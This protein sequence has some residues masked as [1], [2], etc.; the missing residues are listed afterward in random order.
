VLRV[1]AV[2]GLLFEEIIDPAGHKLQMLHSALRH[3]S[4]SAKSSDGIGTEVVKSV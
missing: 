1:R 3:R 2:G 4:S